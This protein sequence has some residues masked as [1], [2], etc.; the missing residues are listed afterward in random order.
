[1]P[2]NGMN[3]FLN[4][5][6][7]SEDVGQMPKRYEVV[8][9]DIVYKISKGVY[10]NGDMLPTESSMLTYYNVSRITVQKAMNILASRGILER[11]PGRGTFVKDAA[12]TR[13]NGHTNSFYAIITPFQEPETLK[14]IK[15]AQDVMS[16][17][18]QYLTVHFTDFKAQDEPQII[19]KLVADGVSG[20]IV[21]ALFS[22]V[23]QA[24]YARLL[25]SDLPVVFVDKSIYGLT[26][27][28]VLADNHNG[29]YQAAEHLIQK[30]HRHIAFISYSSNWGSSLTERLRGFVQCLKDHDLP[31]VPGRMAVNIPDGSLVADNLDKLIRKHPETTAIQCATDHIA[32]LAYEWANN[33]GLRIPQDISIIGFD[34]DI[35][36]ASMNPPMSTIAQDFSLIGTQ[37]AEL[38]LDISKTQSKLKRIIYTPTE[39]VERDSVLDLNTDR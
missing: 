29:A 17:N 10:K 3:M 28:L 4:S 31:L 13:N 23:N 6:I 26:A 14:I 21:Y 27:N 37:A 7:F 16:A 2:L 5:I 30:G 25:R 38:V 34:N 9:N 15:N 22:D 39:L 11:T 32:R 18:D 8:L 33:R 20:I 12:N 24:Y 19:D 35:Y 36:T 1:M